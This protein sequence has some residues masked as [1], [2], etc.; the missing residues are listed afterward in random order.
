MKCSAIFPLIGV[1]ISVGCVARSDDL[2]RKAEG[3]HGRTPY[4]VPCPRVSRIPHP[5][6][7]IFM[8]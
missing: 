2:I 3:M 6:W 8:Y 4:S 5:A 1:D 7:Q